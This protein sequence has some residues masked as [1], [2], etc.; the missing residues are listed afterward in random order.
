MSDKA[1]GVIIGIAL[2][3]VIG[4]VVFN[5]E[6]AQAGDAIEVRGARIAARAVNVTDGGVNLLQEDRETCRRERSLYSA[7]K[8]S[9]FKD[10]PG[11]PNIATMR[12][13]RDSADAACANAETVQTQVTEA[14]EAAATIEREYACMYYTGCDGGS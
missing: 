14:R 3:V 2:S 13:R 10:E 12:I 11:S 5:L 4:G 1:K 9:H 6:G 8:D 7:A